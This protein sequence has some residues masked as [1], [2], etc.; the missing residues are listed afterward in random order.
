MNK[1]TV[2]RTVLAV[3]AIIGVTSVAPAAVLFSET[4]SYPDGALANP[5]QGGVSGGLWIAV[6]SAGFMPVNVSNGKVRLFH[7]TQP[8]QAVPFGQS[9]SRE[10][11]RLGA[12][13]TLY[14]GLDVTASGNSAGAYFAEFPWSQT[15]FAGTKLFIT[16]SSGSDFTFG[17]GD[18]N[19]FSIPTVSWPGGLA[20][21]TTYRV[22]MSYE[23]DTGSS[24]LWVNPA[25]ESSTNVS[26]TDTASR[27]LSTLKLRQYKT[28]EGTPSA[29]QV[30]D[31]LVVA[32]TFDDVL[33]IPAPT[34]AGDYNSDGV[35]NASD[36]VVWRNGLGTIYTQTDYDVWRAHF[37]QTAG[38]GAA[39]PS[40]ESLSTAVPEPAS[41]ALAGIGLAAVGVLTL[42]KR[43]RLHRSSDRG[44]WI[45]NHG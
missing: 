19:S 20:F 37:G 18:E 25:S 32:T 2:L 3:L 7:L 40:A 17:I 29:T 33:A 6:S 15:Q 41:L 43:Q 39:L 1:S 10:F 38:S 36:Y 24:K 9:V 11:S 21:D 22:V 30:L 27:P 31:N 26:I 23:F 34:L 35:V 14:A 16:P 12:G 13:Q 45:T 42:R 44:P 28:P 8:H 4:F 5:P